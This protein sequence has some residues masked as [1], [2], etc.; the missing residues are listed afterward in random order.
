M[1]HEILRGGV[2][3][4]CAAVLAD[5]IAATAFLIAAERFDR[6]ERS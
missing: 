4:V 5:L 2:I 3:I 6:R 1:G